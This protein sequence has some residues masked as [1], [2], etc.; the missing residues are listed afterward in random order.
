[1]AINDI[2]ESL[3]A[4]VAAQL[5]VFGLV[6]IASPADISDLAMNRF[7]DRPDTKKEISDKKTSMFHD[8][9][10]ELQITDIMCSVQEAPDTRQSNT[11]SMDRQSNSKQQKDKLVKR[12]GLE[13]AADE[14]I[15]YL[16]YRQ[17][18]DSDW[19]WKTDGEF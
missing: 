1:M 13:K 15:P 18:W 7:L 9:P 8:F 12:E 2:A 10:E 3:F 6:V 4:V 17:M 5:Q 11:D 16:I 14:F 19:R